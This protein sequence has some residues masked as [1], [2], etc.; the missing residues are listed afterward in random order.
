MNIMTSINEKIYQL[1][2]IPVVAIEDAKD[3]AALGSALIAGDL[4]CA[5]IT[6][7]TAAAAE[8]RRTPRQHLK[9]NFAASRERE[10]ETH[11]CFP[12]P[13]RNYHPLS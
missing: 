13:P 10:G 1:G 2:V 8:T 3:A 6:F 9:N 11:A 5:E 4:P 12:I 7:R